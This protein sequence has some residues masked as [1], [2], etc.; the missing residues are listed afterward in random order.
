MKELSDGTSLPHGGTEKSLLS[1]YGPFFRITW[2]FGL[3]TG[4]ATELGRTRL[5]S[6]QLFGVEFH[7]QPFLNR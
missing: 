1:G 5:G 4:P 2:N 6:T 7:D 3:E